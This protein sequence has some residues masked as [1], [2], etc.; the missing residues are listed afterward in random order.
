MSQIH[1]AYMQTLASKPLVCHSV[2]E[3]TIEQ[4]NCHETEKQKHHLE[5]KHIRQDTCLPKWP[6]TVRIYTSPPVR[7]VHNINR[8]M[9]CYICPVSPYSM[10]GVTPRWQKP[11][12]CHTETQFSRHACS[13]GA[14]DVWN[15]L[16]L[17]LMF[18]DFHVIS[19]DH[20][21]PILYILKIA[22][23]IS[24]CSLIY[25][26]SPPSTTTLHCSAIQ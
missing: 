17:T 5:V 2:Y 13:L 9:A 10:Q 11:S 23:N 22:F 4:Q 24:F 21:R 7:D 14:P 20:Y 26:L 16:P 12:S 3:T 18:T 1:K 6:I 19:D 25:G 8:P 15:N